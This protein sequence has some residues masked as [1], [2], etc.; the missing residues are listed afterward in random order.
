MSVIDFPLPSSEQV[1]YAH[2]FC[3]K[4]GLVKDQSAVILA[5]PF[6][7]AEGPIFKLSWAETCAAQPL[8]HS[9]ASVTGTADCA[10]HHAVSAN[11]AMFDVVAS[12]KWEL[13]DV[14]FEVPEA[15]ASS[16]DTEQLLRI[17]PR[18]RSLCQRRG[19]NRQVRG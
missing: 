1:V 8:T 19:E 12:H 2:S 7:P 5:S 3:W 10:E 11:V 6:P 15:L 16:S 17:R 9:R 4:L 14:L 18:V 13:R